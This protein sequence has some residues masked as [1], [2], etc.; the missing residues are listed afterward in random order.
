MG[1]TGSAEDRTS[2]SDG[3]VGGDGRADESFEVVVQ[4]PLVAFVLL[5]TDASGRPV[6]GQQWDTIVSDQSIPREA[7]GGFTRGV[8]TW[9]L[10][11]F[12]NGG[13]L[14][15][16]DGSLT[17]IGEGRHAL[18]LFASDSGWFQSG[19]HFRLHAL[20]PDGSIVTSAV[21]DYHGNGPVAFPPKVTPPD[22]DA[23]DRG[24][25]AAALGS[26]DL[27]HC[28]SKGALEGGGHVTIT[29]ETSGKVSSVVVDGG[30][31]PGTTAGACIAAAFRKVRVPAFTG[32]PVRVGK[33]VML[34]PG[35]PA[36]L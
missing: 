16:H 24:A 4:G 15:A 20:R 2:P 32:A 14:N 10:G 26:V 11:V 30:P 7:S 6:G 13:L 28:R 21:L 1:R 33:S 5:T 8:S 18:Q 29:F 19:R 34:A 17:P 25:A 36:F 27:R 35:D 31:Y 12:E 22:P 3:V 23:F 9:Q